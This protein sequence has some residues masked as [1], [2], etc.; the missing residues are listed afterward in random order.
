MVMEGFSKLANIPGGQ[1][2]RVVKNAYGILDIVKTGNDRKNDQDQFK[3]VA[4]FYCKNSEK[5]G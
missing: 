1:C 2:R 4:S 3:L 5:T